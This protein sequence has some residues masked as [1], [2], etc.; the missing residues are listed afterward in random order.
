MHSYF[1]M[2]NIIAHGILILIKTHYLHTDG[3]WSL[4]G[5]NPVQKK[6]LDNFPYEFSCDSIWPI[7]FSFFQTSTKSTTYSFFWTIFNVV[8][9]LSTLNH[10]K[11]RNNN[12]NGLATIRFYINIWCVVFQNN[13]PWKEMLFFVRWDE[14]NIKIVSFHPKNSL[15]K[16]SLW[17]RA[18]LYPV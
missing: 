3:L 4:N 15:Q 7:F 6:I 13:F 17:Y 11:L 14:R 8:V 18:Y 9:E 2:K 1:V 5:Q 16:F 10:V 12:I